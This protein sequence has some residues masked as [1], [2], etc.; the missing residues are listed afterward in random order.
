MNGIEIKAPNVLPSLWCIGVLMSL[1]WLLAMRKH[2]QVRRAIVVSVDGCKVTR[3]LQ[4]NK[5][6]NGVAPMFQHNT[7]GV[8]ALQTSSALPLFPLLPLF[9]FFN[10]CLTSAV[11]VF[12]LPVSS[13]S[14]WRAPVSSHLVGFVRSVPLRP[15][16]WKPSEGQED[17]R[18]SVHPCLNFSLPSF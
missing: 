16:L 13:S 3:L 15:A 7:T 14:G 4:T 11:S 17:D 5:K 1:L 8:G 18:R 2:F 12:P 10:S 6:K 9:F